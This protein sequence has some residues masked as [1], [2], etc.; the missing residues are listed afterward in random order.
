MGIFQDVKKSSFKE[1]DAIRIFR[2]LCMYFAGF[3][4]STDTPYPYP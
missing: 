3:L 4:R 1:D 2:V